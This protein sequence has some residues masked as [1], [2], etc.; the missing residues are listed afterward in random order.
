M[1]AEKILEGVKSADEQVPK[2]E[3]CTLGPKL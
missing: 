1:T 3:P 2:P